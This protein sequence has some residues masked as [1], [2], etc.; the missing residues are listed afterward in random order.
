VRAVRL[1]NVDVCVPSLGPLPEAFVG[2]IRRSL[3]VHHLLVSAAKGRGRARQELIGMVDTE[4]F[5]FVDTDVVLREDWWQ[6]VSGYLDDDVGAVEGLWRYS[7]DP[8]VEAYNQAMNRLAGLLHRPSSKIVVAKAFTGDTLIRTELVKDIRIPDINVYEDEYIRQHVEARGARWVRTAEP[9]C[10][11]T[12]KYNLKEAFDAGRMGYV[13][14]HLTLS[15]QVTRTFAKMPAKLAFTLLTLR[16]P[17]A[18]CL[19]FQR[20]TRM[21]SGVLNAWACGARKTRD[22]R[23]S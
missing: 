6:I 1:D 14:G 5:V 9:V 4:W 19:E 7:E 10:E 23:E 12:R 15:D 3:P 16:S 22:V 8:R 13:F 11:H 18:A 2:N 21:F 20:Q 17:A